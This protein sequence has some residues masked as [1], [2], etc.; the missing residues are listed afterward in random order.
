MDD[1]SKNLRKFANT[2]CYCVD[3]LVFDLSLEET[4][5]PSE[6][7][8]GILCSDL[9]AYARRGDSALIAQFFKLVLPG[10]I[11]TKHVFRGLQRPLLADAD[12][13]ADEKKL[14]YTRKPAYDYVWDDARSGSVMQLDAPAGGVF[15][16]HITP[17]VKHREQYPEIAGWIDHWAWIEEDA[18]LPEAPTGWVDRYNEKLWTRG[19][20]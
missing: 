16:V 18:G 1:C 13:Q 5:N 17:N 6:G 8:L 4:S 10:I 14:I 19:C 7:V 2:W 3:A 12:N 20:E 9:Q 11:L 15:A